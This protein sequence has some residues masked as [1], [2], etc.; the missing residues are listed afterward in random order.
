MPTEPTEQ[1][2]HK[3]EAQLAVAQAGQYFGHEADSTALAAA[4]IGLVHSN[5]AIAEELR[6]IRNSIGDYLGDDSKLDQ[7]AQALRAVAEPAKY[8]IDPRSHT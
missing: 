7:I 3:A 8:G 6:G 2:D 4:A 5:L 1:V